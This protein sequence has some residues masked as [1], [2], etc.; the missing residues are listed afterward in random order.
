[1][2]P[3]MLR[4]ER[5]TFGV[6]IEFLIATIREGEKDPHGDVEGIQPVLRVPNGIEPRDYAHSRV[7]EVLDECF[8]TLSSRETESL[9]PPTILETYREW[10]VGLDESLLP[11]RSETYNQYTWAAIE[12][13][14]P[15]QYASPRGFEAINFAISAITSRFRCH[16]NPSCGLH[17]HVGLGAERIPLEHMR[18]MASLSYAVEPLLFALL[19]P[20]REV[21]INCKQL[22]Y[23]SNLVLEDPE[24][25]S[26]VLHNNP[27][28][29]D[30]QLYCTQVGRERRHGEAPL[31]AREANNDPAHID[32]FLE[33]RK[34]G[35]YE[36]FTKPGDSRHTVLLPSDIS[37]EI[38]SRIS[39]AQL[40][41]P[42]TTPPA[43]PARQRGITRLGRKNYNQVSLTRMNYASQ[44][45]GAD[46]W[47]DQL[48]LRIAGR[49]SPSVF[50]ATERI[51]AQPSTCNIG[52]LLTVIGG[53]RS[54]ISFHH[55][56]CFQFDP[57]MTSARTIEVRMSQGSL[58]GEYIVTWA[59]ILT[60]LFRFALYSSPSEFI[61]LMTKCERAA[62]VEGSYDVVDLLD[63]IGLFAE[64][65]IVEK[66]LIANKDEWDLKFVEPKA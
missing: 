31:L 2:S 63:D 52:N 8:G 38:D 13:A 6:E 56:R 18:R 62:K 25:D 58:D 54:T 26:Q 47:T 57:P 12:I 32:A 53:T 44:R 22:Q 61:D 21:N 43:E 66:R 7:R 49:P 30:Y 65:V 14:S 10:V 1:M 55:Y 5:P 37:D 17:V 23:Y 4:N 16:V 33:T 45:W 46:L 24:L 42:S 3:S 29:S 60:G 51:Y 50:E 36:P 28:W 39:T 34:A 11:S 41:P 20:S 15:V 27:A 35:H 19:D 9:S 64:A 40:P 59:K 48:N